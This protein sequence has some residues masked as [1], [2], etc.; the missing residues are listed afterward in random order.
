MT[1][2]AKKARWATEAIGPAKSVLG[3]AGRGLVDLPSDVTPGARQVAQLTAWR[4]AQS[5]AL[6]PVGAALDELR[7]L[8][9]WSGGFLVAETV[10]FDWRTAP[11]KH[12]G[13]FAHFYHEEL[14]S[15]WDAW[16]Q[17]QATYRKLIT[18]D[19]NM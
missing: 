9:D 2:L 18:G 6:G 17:L 14:E 7:K 19:R 15:T 10:S 16:D 12:Y 1:D 13:S 5:Y 11:F 8:P 3:H 4:A